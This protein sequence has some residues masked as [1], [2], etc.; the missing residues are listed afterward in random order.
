MSLVTYNGISLP[1]PLTTQFSQDPV[2][3]E[4]GN[5]DWCGTK[6]TITIQCVINYQYLAA[7]SSD[8][9]LIDDGNA[10][11]VMDLIRRK[12]LEPRRTLSF[13]NAG[14]DLIPPKA[15]VPGTVDIRN[16]PKPLS[17]QIFEM[18]TETFFLSFSIEAVY[19]EHYG[20]EIEITPN[21]QVSPVMFNRWSETVEIDEMLMSR[22]TREGKYIIRSDNTQGLT[23]D[24]ARIGMAVLAV[25][26]GFT[27]QISRY[28]ITPDGL[29]L[30]Y[31]ITDQENYKLPP[32]PA[33]KASGQY[34]IT[35]PK[36]GGTLCYGEVYLRL[37]G[38][39]S[40]QLSPQTKLVTVAIGIAAG[41]LGINGASQLQS[42]SVM[43][44]MFRNVVEV[45]M[46]ALMNARQATYQGVTMAQSFANNL[47]F[48]PGV[49]NQKSQRGQGP[50]YWPRGTA[51]LLL[52]AAAYYD[53]NVNAKLT[54]GT[55]ADPADNTPPSPLATQMPGLIPGQAGKQVED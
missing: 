26:T 12:L 32:Q 44:D 54:R 55:V 40:K 6:Y 28:T 31:L 5:V 14:I 37:E 17:C 48:T 1:Y 53:P 8:Y 51:S 10:S 46:R 38:A 3:D 23:A 39:K 50:V 35:S 41:K 30:R 42:A 2:Y 15:G 29:G 11:T 9:G 43:T 21:R 36:P 24:Q 20:S 7:M 33:Y 18:N 16:G 22:R 4:E 45:R 25:P 47:C 34:V 13:T 27:R 19:W 52:Q 49:D